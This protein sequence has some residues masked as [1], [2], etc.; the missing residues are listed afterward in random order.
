MHSAVAVD[1]ILETCP[2]FSFH[3]DVNTNTNTST[4]LDEQISKAKK[5]KV[6]SFKSLKK[7]LP[8][9]LFD[10]VQQP[11]ISSQENFRSGGVE[12]ASSRISAK[13]KIGDDGLARR[14][15]VSTE[16]STSFSR[17]YDL[18]GQ[19]LGSKS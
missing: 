4:Q 10:P 14:S 13:P 17:F 5:K 9:F 18:Q 15:L 3:R 6:F 12:Q 2:P 19:S 8:D 16:S 7:Y 1:S 11:A